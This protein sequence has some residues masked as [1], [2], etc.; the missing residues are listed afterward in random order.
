MEDNRRENGLEFPKLSNSSDLSGISGSTW[1]CS[2]ES[3]LWTRGD[4]TRDV[5]RLPRGTDAQRR[6][7]NVTFRC[8]GLDLECDG[9]SIGIVKVYG[10]GDFLSE[11]SCNKIES[12]SALRQ[13]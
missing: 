12:G 11:G 2:V 9:L 1:P 6:S 10:N 8:G 3:V 4:R 5:N 13:L 7:N